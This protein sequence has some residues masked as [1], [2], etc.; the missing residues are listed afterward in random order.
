LLAFGSE[1][2][3]VTNGCEVGVELFHVGYLVKFGFDCL[4]MLLFLL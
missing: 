1:E 3:V 4:F 2:G